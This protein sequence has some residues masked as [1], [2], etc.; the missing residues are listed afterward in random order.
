MAV[1]ID[2]LRFPNCLFVHVN[3]PTYQQKMEEIQKNIED[4]R[5]KCLLLG[6]GMGLGFGINLC[7]GIKTTNRL[8]PMGCI[9]KEK[10]ITCEGTPNSDILS[11]VTNFSK[12]IH[13]E[14]HD[15][16]DIISDR[17][18]DLNRR[19]NSDEIT[20]SPC[21]S[22]DIKDIISDSPLVKSALNKELFENTEYL[23]V[24]ELQNEEKIRLTFFEC[25]SCL[26]TFKRK[27][28]FNRH[29]KVMFDCRLNKICKEPHD[30][31]YTLRKFSS[32]E[33][34]KAYCSTLGKS[35][36]NNID[37][38]DEYFKSYCTF[39]KR[40]GCKASWSLKKNGLTDFAFTGCLKHV[41]SCLEMDHTRNKHGF[42]RGRQKRGK[43]KKFKCE[44]CDFKGVALKLHIKS[45][46]DKIKDNVCQE[47]G[48]ACSNKGTLDKHIKA[49]HLKLKDYVCEEC[50]S[51]FFSKANLQLHK[52]S[53]H[54]NMR[55]Y[56]CEECGMAFNRKSGLKMHKEVVHRK[57]KKFV[58]QCGYATALSGN[59]K[60]H[61]AAVHKM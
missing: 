13:F 43:S 59:L 27:K 18:E 15:I 46:H 52:Q 10:T 39:R 38:K 4:E 60:K 6:F 42:K 5:L 21:D 34:A 44:K 40:L 54:L 9:L 58:C 33:E 11:D 8:A 37:G 1:I 48:Y 12:D 31:D 36:T 22:P 55:N 61:K 49:V 28:A 17:L 51:A 23:S 14:N 57:I 45:V 2:I 30:H 56:I 19:D 24:A 35:Q 41:D 26:G 3:N 47:C 25:A 50:G 29:Q 7:T 32:L 16:T 20:D 53:V